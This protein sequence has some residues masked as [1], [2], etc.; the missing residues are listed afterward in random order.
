MKKTINIKTKSKKYKVIVEKG[1]LI[2][3]FNSQISPN[4]KYFIVLDSKIKNSI[5]KK[6]INKKNIFLLKINSNEKIKSLKFYK[7]II[8]FLLKNNVNRSSTLIA[9][10][11]GTIG[12][13]SGFVASTILRGIKFVL[14]PSTLLSQVDSSIGGKNGIN[15]NY[16]K[17]LVG[18][19]YQPDLVII[20]PLI[21]KTLNKKQMR[22]G[23]AEIFKHALINDINFYKWLKNNYNKI[24]QCNMKIL[25][26]AIYKSIIIKA[27]FVKNDE[28]ETI[29]NNFSRF[30]LNFGHTFGHALETFN[31]Y[32]L[33]LSH[34]EAIA[35]GM[36]VVCKI[37]YKLKKLDK[38]DYENIVA[39]L[40]KVGLPVNSKQIYNKKIYKIIEMD[41]KNI[42]G[43]VNLILLNKIGKPYRETN[44]DIN[45]I[46]NLLN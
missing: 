2:N 15:T 39:H 6:I 5:P 45:K 36:V 8:S 7:Q 27:K 46:K 9:I 23:Y 40:K 26:Y 42:N 24:I 13:L 44:L 14:I 41:K 11:G 1:C 10:G 33:N 20:D 16:G 29:N 38:D 22:S 17:N 12:D 31:K 35:I 32:R 37:S 4:K 19:F 43:K 28:K 3:F 25:S 18:T 34:G 30:F 21:L